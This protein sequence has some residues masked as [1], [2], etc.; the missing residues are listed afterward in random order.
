MDLVSTGSV[1]SKHKIDSAFP[2]KELKVILDENIE[3]KME[4][5][6]NVKEMTIDDFIDD[7]KL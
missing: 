7:F 1:I 2:L 4:D 5:E 6:S 3:V